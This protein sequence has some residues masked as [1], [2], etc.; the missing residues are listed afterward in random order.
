MSVNQ[1]KTE[2]SLLISVPGGWG[3]RWPRSRFSLITVQQ[4]GE[5]PKLWLVS[6]PSLKRTQWGPCQDQKCFGGK[7]KKLRGE[8][9]PK[10]VSGAT[11]PLVAEEDRPG[12]SITSKCPEQG[13]MQKHTGGP[14]P[15]LP[16]PHGRE[17]ESRR[18]GTFTRWQ[19]D[20]SPWG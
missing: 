6:M 11:W 16:A 2:E 5:E 9:K 10:R 8:D 3:Q 1:I 20:K 17:E 15:P 18:F 14:V 7:E 4:G 13:G 12:L 19:E